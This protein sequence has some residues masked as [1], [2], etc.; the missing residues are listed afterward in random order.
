A[1][2]NNNGQLDP[3]FGTGGKMIAALD[4]GGDQLTAIA[5]QA[6]GKIVAAGSVIH[7]NWQLSFLV[8]RF[9]PNGTLDSNFGNGGTILTNFGDS[10]AAANTLVLQPDGKITVAGVSGAGPYSELNDFALA[11]YN[12]NGSLDQTFGNGGKVKT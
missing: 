1:R 5:L 6:D 10:Y 7:D 9:N 11:R 8:A 3:T 4:P 2:Y 12:S